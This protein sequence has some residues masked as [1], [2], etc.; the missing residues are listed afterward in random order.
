MEQLQA[1]AQ[2]PELM[3]EPE[4]LQEACARLQEAQDKVE[5]LYERWEKLEEIRSG[6][7]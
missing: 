4:K 7:K 3:N 6:E 1:V 2:S 5:T